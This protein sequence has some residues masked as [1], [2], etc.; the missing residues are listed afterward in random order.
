MSIS[1]VKGTTTTTRK[2]LQSRHRGK[3]GG[4]GVGWGRTC[5]S[6]CHLEIIVFN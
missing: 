2:L 5:D 3:G 1:D 4:G 6:V